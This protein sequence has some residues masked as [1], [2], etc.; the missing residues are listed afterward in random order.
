MRTAPIAFAALAFWLA[1]CRA[2]PAAGAGGLAEDFDSTWQDGR[3]AF[4]NGQEFPGAKGSFERSHEAAHAGTWGGELSFD[5]SGG[6]NY[7]AAIL[8]LDNA[9]DVAAVRVW[10]KKPRGNRL[11][12]RYTD[13]TGQTL[14]KGFLAP[15][16]KWADVLIPMVGWTGH[17]G[18]ANDGQPH[19][20]PKLIALLVENTG[21]TQGTVLIDN[22]R[23][24]EGKPEEGAGMVTSEY[25]AARFTPDEGWRLNVHGG[26]G[27]STKLDGRTW[28]FDFTKGARSIGIVPCDFSLL[29]M[30]KEFRIRVRGNPGGHPLRVQLAT[31]FMMFEGTVGPFVPAAGGASECV[32]QAPPGEG[33]KWYW[34]ENDGKI[35]GPLRLRGIF[36]EA[37]G[38]SDAGELELLEVR[39]KTQCALDRACVMLAERKESEGGEFVATI[40][41][42]ALKETA[43]TVAWAVRDWAG[44]TLKEG[45]AKVA[46][47]A[48]GEPVEVRLAMPAAGHKFLEAEFAMEAEGQVIPPAQAYYTAPPEARGAA[49][50]EPASPFGMGLY[51]Y[52]YPGN[53]EGLKEMDRAAQMAQDAGV[54][55]SREEFGWAGIEREKGKSDWA[56]YDSVVATAKRH[57]ISVYGLLS[58]WATWTKPY[59]PEGIEDY[60]RFAAAAAERYKDDIRH[61]EV[62]NEPNIFFWQGPRDMYADLLKQ[63]YAAIKKANPRALVLG[64]STAG[65]DFGFIKRTMELGAPFDI[66]TIHP[67]RATLNDAA[68]IADLRKAADLAKGPDGRLR[69]AWITEM[70]W[71][72]HVAHNGPAQDFQATTQRRQAN[73]LARAYIDAIASGVSPNVSWYDFRND[74]DDPFNFEHNMGIVDRDF[75]P[76]PAYRALATVTQ[77]LAGKKFSRILDLGPGITAYR[78]EDAKGGTDTLVLWTTDKDRACALPLK[79]DQPATAVDLMGNR[80]SLKAGQEGRLRLPLQ[81][82]TPIFVVVQ[83]Q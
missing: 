37:G 61:W 20:P 8:R 33:W 50:P 38:Q 58:Y 34:G 71:G 49:D 62:W 32:F 30:P 55:W 15:D 77:M 83:K 16:D 18:G 29:G 46:A 21:Q 44:R 80:E 82:E 75:T 13:G 19:G 35:H 51:L 76:K 65:I 81:Q 78:F 7:V 68:F 26:D 3:W 12:F 27:G 40:R 1:G 5:F 59:T 73:L 79:A 54:K 23:I 66:L 63:A 42:L 28:R 24:I 9:P 11:T 52:R 10:V 31:H 69:E 36:L 39:A 57:G 22:V 67:Y 60:C 56:F 53:A 48:G 70:G 14:Q 43:G 74:G 47:S 45:S 41:S 6:G 17:W 72:T 2:A 64:C 25:A 4:S